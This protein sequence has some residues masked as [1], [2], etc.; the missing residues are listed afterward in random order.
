M[1]VVINSIGYSNGTLSLSS[2]N[3]ETTVFS[4]SGGSTDAII[5]GWISLQNMQSGDIT[6]VTVYVT[7]DGTNYYVFL[8]RTFAG[9]VS[10][11]IMRI[12]TLQIPPGM[13]IKV[14]INQVSG[15]ARSYPYYFVIQV[16]SS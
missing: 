14:T 9:P 12:H 13:G 10:N 2:L 7:V 8:Q 11:P 4:F 16:L 3:T 6:T 5:E 15:T 1:P